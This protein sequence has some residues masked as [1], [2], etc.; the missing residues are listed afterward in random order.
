M[1]SQDRP[2][3]F[4]SRP[5]GSLT[6]LI[7]VDDLPLTL[8][9]RGVSRALTPGETQGMTSCGVATPRVEPWIVDGAPS[10]TCVMAD[11]RA[12]EIRSL[13]FK[14]LREDSV[15][16]DTRSAIQEV[17]FR[18]F[19][20]PSPIAT[21]GSFP[22][23]VSV[24]AP[25][26]LSTFGHVTQSASQSGFANTQEGNV[27]VSQKNAH[28]KKQY[29]S[30]W[31]RHGE[32][33]YSQQG[34]LYKH[35]MPMDTQLLEKLG[36][37]DIP[38]WYREK[39][40]VASLQAGH[41]IKGGQTQYALT[42]NA[43]QPPSPSPQRSIEW[44]SSVN[45]PESNETRANQSRHKTPKSPRGPGFGPGKSRGNVTKLQQSRKNYAESAN[46]TPTSSSA[47][48]GDSFV[49]PH[50]PSHSLGAP[51]ASAQQN[52]SKFS[53]QNKHLLGKADMT[54]KRLD[55][56]ASFPELTVEESVQT[57]SKSGFRTKSR[58]PY[59]Y[60]R[61][62]FGGDA[63]VQSPSNGN[64]PTV[65]PTNR[66]NTSVS[67]PVSN[68]VN[69]DLHRHV[70]VT[71]NLG[72]R[73]VR[74]A[75]VPDSRHASPNFKDPEQRRIYNELLSNS[76]AIHP[77]DMEYTYGAIGEPVEYPNTSSNSSADSALL[78]NLDKFFDEAVK[79]NAQ[80]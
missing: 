45:T 49:I 17:L 3:F 30:Y 58:R 54:A 6:P 41:G 59:E 29:C 69:S 52:A 48:S 18:G 61:D 8:S 1:G 26:T 71:T 2:S 33:D 39:F 15:Q 80:A 47:S 20:A 79:R 76:E 68:V 66:P 56:T 62:K 65:N 44:S 21:T 37:R 72:S 19:D 50:A 22:S 70:A 31:I 60:D 53:V 32:C 7:A 78:S 63:N 55:L 25:G 16:G 38:R 46:V 74:P 43:H 5:D 4:C 73:F 35:E 14:I 9:V 75:V 12:H 23:V 36:L 42:E 28:S 77:R 34:C 64:P 40:S 27:Q 13:L 67:G 10:D 51:L 57:F 11:E 24:P